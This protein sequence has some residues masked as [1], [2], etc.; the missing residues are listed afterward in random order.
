MFI[1]Y[2]VNQRPKLRSI[3]GIHTKQFLRENHLV[4]TITFFE[5]ESKR[6]NDTIDIDKPPAL[7][8]QSGIGVFFKKKNSARKILLII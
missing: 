4:F 8:R 2:I 7:K 1:S 5:N 6:K 3:V